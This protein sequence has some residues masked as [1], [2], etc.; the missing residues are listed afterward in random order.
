[1][2]IYWVPLFGKTWKKQRNKDGEL[3]HLQETIPYIVFFLFKLIIFI[4]LYKDFTF[5]NFTCAAYALRT[6]PPLLMNP[7]MQQGM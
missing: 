1:M 6:P 4:L 5:Y 3:C 7:P 2:T